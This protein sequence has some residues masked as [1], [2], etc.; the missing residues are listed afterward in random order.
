MASPKLRSTR[1]TLASAPPPRPRAAPSR[2][3]AH[4]GVRGE[5]PG[6]REVRPRVVGA[7]RR[8]ALEERQR[9]LLLGLERRPRGNGRPGSRRRNGSR[10]RLAG[11]GPAEQVERLGVAARAEAGDRVV[12]APLVHER[13]RLG[14]GVAASGRGRVATAGRRREQDERARRRA[15]AAPASRRGRRRASGPPELLDRAVGAVGHLRVR[16]GEQRGQPGD[17]G[18]VAELRQDVAERRPAPRRRGRSGTGTGPGAIDG[19]SSRT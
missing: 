9:L 4:Q 14:Q 12:E 10:L 17:R 7:R 2:S 16:V 8:G 1:S 5:E 6:G 19:P 3:R 15:R 18:D 11:P 13:P